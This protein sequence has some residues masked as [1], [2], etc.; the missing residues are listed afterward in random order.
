MAQ[1][2]VRKPST[3]HRPPAPARTG[4]GTGEQ[5]S[6]SKNQ[7]PYFS[8]KYHQTQNTWDPIYLLYNV[9][10][11]TQAPCFSYSLKYIFGSTFCRYRYLSTYSIFFFVCSPDCLNCSRFT[12][13]TDRLSSLE[14]KVQSWTP[15]LK[16]VLQRESTVSDH[17]HQCLS[18]FERHWH[19][20]DRWKHTRTLQ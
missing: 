6:T 9:L 10:L 8:F 18:P 14:E 13:L 20:S 4:T 16:T 3:L 2:A 15:L 1:E 5:L 17:E 7:E 12:A 11:N 19:F